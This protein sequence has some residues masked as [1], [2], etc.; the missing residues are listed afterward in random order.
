MRVV[1]LKNNTKCSFNSNTSFLL[2]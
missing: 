1:L 2:P